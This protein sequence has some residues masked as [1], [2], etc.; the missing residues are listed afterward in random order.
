M[1]EE[2]DLYILAI[3]NTK[4]QFYDMCDEKGWLYLKPAGEYFYKYY[5]GRVCGHIA[6]LYKNDKAVERG[7]DHPTASF[8]EIV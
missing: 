7:K 8:N 1:N 4:A 3:K 5:S 2:N 6:I